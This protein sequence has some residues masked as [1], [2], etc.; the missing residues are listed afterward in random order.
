MPRFEMSILLALENDSGEINT[1]EYDMICWADNPNDDK[2]VHDTATK[3]VDEHTD[4][5]VDLKK[6]VLFGI[7]YIKVNPD[8]IMNLFF[9]NHKID[10]KKIKMV[11]DLY[12]HYE[13]DK[14]IH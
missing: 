13:D 9:E 1:E 8:K 3:I 5:L 11:M 4:R 10:K 6:I 12:S 14:R 7:A 2:K